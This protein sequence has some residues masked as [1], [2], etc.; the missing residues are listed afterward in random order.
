MGFGGDEKVSEMSTYFDEPL[1]ME[2]IREFV[3]EYLFDFD[4]VASCQRMGFS[5]EASCSQGPAFLK[6]PGTQ[7]AIR[8]SMESDELPVGMKNRVVSLLVKE[9]N[10]RGPNA[11]HAARVSALRQLSLIYGMEDIPGKDA[12]R[13]KTIE[14]TV[15]VVPGI[16]EA[17]DWEETAQLQQQKLIEA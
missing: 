9:A 2:Q 16:A 12:E 5:F 13:N 8:E 7:R 14:G 11:S 17:D 10:E 1:P 4:S 15:M 6:D 3:Q